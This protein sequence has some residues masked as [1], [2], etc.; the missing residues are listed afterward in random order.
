[1][2]LNCHPLGTDHPLGSGRPDPVHG[3]L[4]PSS[5]NTGKSDAN[6]IEFGGKKQ[7]L[8]AKLLIL[9]VPI[10]QKGQEAFPC[11]KYIRGRAA[12]HSSLQVPQG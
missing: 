8:D 11:L 2:S 10:Y 9:R 1:M 12:P 5:A 7:F 3:G 6:S 4:L